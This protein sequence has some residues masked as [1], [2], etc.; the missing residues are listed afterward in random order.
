MPEKFQIRLLLVED[1]ASLRGFLAEEL[2]ENG[3]SVLAAATLSEGRRLLQDQIPDIILSDLKLPDGRG[4]SLLDAARGLPVPPPVILITAF[5]QVDEAVDALRK[6]ISDFLTKPLDVDHLLLRL[7]H[8]REV[9]RLRQLVAAMHAADRGHAREG[10]AMLGG[11]PVWRQIEKQIS[12]IAMTDDP[13]LL[14]GPSGSGKEVV[15][16]SIHD[17]SRRRDKPFIPVNCSGLPEQ[18]LESE[19]FGHQ[20]GSFTGASK[21]RRGLFSA[22]EG[23]TL[24]LD[25]IGDMPVAMQT[26]LLRTLQEGKIRP[27]G[28]DHEKAV[29]L[30]IIASTNRNL[31]QRMKQ[32]AFREDLF[33]RLETFHLKLPPLK[34]RPEDIELFVSHFIAESAREVKRPVDGISEEAMELLKAYSFPGNVRELKNIIRRAVTFSDSRQLRTK[35]LPEKLRKSVRPDLA[36]FSLPAQL[37]TMETLRRDY[38]RHVL[39]ACAGNKRQTARILGI[40]RQTLYSLLQDNP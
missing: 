24:L 25:E 26:K 18:L 20:A 19:L 3:Y 1:D 40:S 28:S 32:Q 5:G 21:S 35:D 37:V 34:D 16:R 30:R 13:V 9:Q 31:E 29:D 36:G 11:S 7:E 27:L 39:A 38:A 22:A 10:V 8:M 12:R 2:E 14:T 4:D 6:G 23:G 15:A 33:Y 17:L